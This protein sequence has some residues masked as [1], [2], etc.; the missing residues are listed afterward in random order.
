MVARERLFARLRDGRGL[1]LTLVACP[2]GF[3]KSTLLAAWRERDAEDR[4]G[5]WVTLDEGD[6][7]A[8]VL[9]AH[10]IEALGRVCPGIAPL[11]ASVVSAPLREVVLPRLVNQ[12]AEAGRRR[13]RA[14]RLP[15]ASRSA[16][17]RDSVAW[18]AEHLPATVQLVL[19]DPRGP[20]PPAR[21]AA[22]ARPAARAA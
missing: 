18:F 1:N 9:W 2:A 19:V 7:D 17:A 3:G 10:V 4:P 15:P 21:R 5:A 16:A 12:L 8:V 22:R 11:A 14:R 20:R 13:A 6:D